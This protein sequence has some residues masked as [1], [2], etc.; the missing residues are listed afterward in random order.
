[1]DNNQSK[2]TYDLPN[3]FMVAAYTFCNFGQ[4]RANNGSGKLYEHY[5]ILMKTYLSKI[6]APKIKSKKGDAMIQVHF[7]FVIV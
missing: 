7:F 5:K 1:M 6:V 4:Q 3:H 2:K